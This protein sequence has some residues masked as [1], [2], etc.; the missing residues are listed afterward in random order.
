MLQKLFLDVLPV[1]EST[2]HDASNQRE[3]FRG[4]PF[5]DEEREVQVII[6]KIVVSLFVERFLVTFVALAQ[7]LQ[8]QCDVALSWTV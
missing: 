6:D 7:A 4:T 2:F 3:I 8:T 5:F 1:S